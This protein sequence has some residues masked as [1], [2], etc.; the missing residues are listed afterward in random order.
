MLRA[1]IN[2]GFPSFL[3]LDNVLQHVDQVLFNRTTSY[4]MWTRCCSTGQHR[5][6]RRP[7]AVQQDNILQHVD[8]VLFNWTT[9][10]NMWTR[11]CSTGQHLTTCGPGAV[12]LDNILQHVDQVLFNR[13]TSY[14]T[15]HTKIMTSSKDSIFRC[16]IQTDDGPCFHTYAQK[17]CIV[18]QCLIVITPLL[19]DMY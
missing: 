2:K 11:C 16:S 19:T 1:S 3:Q 8:Q 17:S 4:N 9:S 12:Q 15:H 5:T 14:N 13:T 6:T 10:Y 18:T 7:G